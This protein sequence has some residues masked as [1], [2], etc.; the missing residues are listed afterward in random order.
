[1]STANQQT[2]E[3]EAESRPSL[4][5]KGSYAPWASWFLRF[6]DN[7]GEEGELMRNS[8]DNDP[9]K[10]K[11]IVDPN[12]DTQT[13][14]EPINKLS[15]Q[16]QN[17]TMQISSKYVTLTRQK[18]VLKKEHF[19]VLY[20]YLSQFEPH[21]KASKA[22]KAARNHDPVA[23]VANSH[24]NHSYSHAS[25]LYSRSPQTYY[26]THPSFMIDYDDD[27]QG[28][29]QGDGQED[30]LSTAMM[31]LARDITQH[32][33]TPTNNQI[34][35]SSNTRNQVMIQDGRVD[36]QIKNVRYAGNGNMY[37]GRTN[38]NQ[39][40]NASNGFVQKIKKYEQNM[41]LAT[42]DEEENDFMLVNAYGDDTLEELNA[43]V[44]MMALIQPTDDKENK[45]LDDIVTLEEKLKSHEQIVFKRSH[46]LQ[47]I[48][49]L[50]KKQNVFY[51]PHMKTG[52]GYQNPK[53]LKKAIEEQPK[54]YNGKNL[55]NNKLKIDLPDYGETLEDA[56]ESR[57]KVK[58]KM[59]P[60]DYP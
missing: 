25:P 52:L 24:A 40:T 29:I 42:K 54:I 60:L 56:E 6:L 11:E 41:L 35:T 2:A 28:E 46:S 45:Y 14:L 44:I 31:L 1:M 51:D 49:M 27:Y 7:K 20:D 26:V 37:A 19:D 21:V 3:S 43:S 12:D 59:I 53:R 47:T 55:N 36:I 22:K 30:K 17:N 34:R 16:D 8:I 33:S 4:L 5:E 57:L 48:H 18:F 38:K 58:D 10:R 13:I 15:P 39:E 32:Y 50:G 9:Y 23:L